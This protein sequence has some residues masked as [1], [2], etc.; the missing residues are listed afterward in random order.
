MKQIVVALALLAIPSVA[1]GASTGTNCLP[2][3]LKARLAEVQ[4]KFGPVKGVS[5]HRPG[6]KS[7]EL[8]GPHYM[9][10]A[11]PLISFRPKANTGRS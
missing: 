7:G 6:A 3:S 9:R 5:T 4:R 8:V 10:H 11:V 2:G 1:L